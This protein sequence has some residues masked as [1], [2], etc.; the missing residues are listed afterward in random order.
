MNTDVPVVAFGGSYGGLFPG[1]FVTLCLLTLWLFA[2]M[3]A[4]WFRMVHAHL[5]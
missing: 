3:L 4:G 2:G 1:G 5:A